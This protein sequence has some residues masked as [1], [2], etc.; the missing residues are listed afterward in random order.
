M[1]QANKE[2]Q[3]IIKDNQSFIDQTIEKYNNLKSTFKTS[4]LVPT[5]DFEFWANLEDISV[6]SEI[7]GLGGNINGFI[8]HI[9]ITKTKEILEYL[10]L[11]A[12]FC[13]NTSKAQELYNMQKSFESTNGKQLKSRFIQ[14]LKSYNKNTMNEI[15][16][17][18]L[19]YTID[20]FEQLFKKKRLRSFSLYLLGIAYNDLESIKDNCFKEAYAKHIKV[21]IQ[22]EEIDL[23]SKLK[24]IE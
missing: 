3:Q 8:K 13:I 15:G 21:E 24:E 14:L 6:K 10:N 16:Y 23:I 9:K 22:M 7:V 5:T 11:D 4:K 18:E 20:S 19:H 1:K 2:L 12:V 17:K